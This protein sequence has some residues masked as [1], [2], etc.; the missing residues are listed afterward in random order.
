MPHT[1]R[2]AIYKH[3]KRGGGEVLVPLVGVLDDDIAKYQRYEFKVVFDR[4]S[5]ME[6]SVGYDAVIRLRKRMDE[7]GLLSK[8]KEM[9][10]YF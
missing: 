9:F 2:L 1:F 10:N 3:C 6:C 8:L 7:K 5:A 4:L